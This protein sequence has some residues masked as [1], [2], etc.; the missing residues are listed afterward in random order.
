MELQ[1]SRGGCEYE[2]DSFCVTDD[3]AKEG[4]DMER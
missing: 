2:A 3:E 4:V 1:S